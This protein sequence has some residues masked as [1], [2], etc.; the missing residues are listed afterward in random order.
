M[1]DGKRLRLL[2]VGATWPPQ[3][4]L[5]RLMRG[6]ADS[7]VVDVSLAF[8]QKPDQEWFLRSRLRA[9]R[10][11]PWEGPRL[12]RLLRVAWL[13]L[14]AL[15]RSPADFRRYW[16]RSK[17]ENGL[18][19]RL[20]LLNRLLPFAGVSFDVL[21]FPWNSAA[22]DY[23]PLFE[24]GMP[25][26]LSCRGSQI[27]VAPHDP[28]RGIRKGLPGTFAKSA[29]VHC[30]SAAI[31]G[32]AIKFGLD[33]AKSKVIH[34]GI[35]PEFFSPPAARTPSNVLRII[36]VGSLV[37]VKGT[38]YA[39]QALRALLDRGVAAHL[40]L[41]GD[42]PERQRVL[43]T[44]DDL[45]LWDHVELAGRLT[46]VAV[47]DRLREADVFI[48]PSLSEGFCNAAIEA[49]ACGVPVVMSNCGGV[50]EGV[51]DGIEGFIVPTRDPDA[52]A[53]A[54][55]RLARDPALRLQMGLAGRAR[56]L[57]QFALSKHVQAFVRLLEEV[58]DCRVA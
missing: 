32:E 25:V 49:M 46:P 48:L 40:T 11:R 24:N 33:R 2:V 35:D 10:T 19:N 37:W 43:F 13:S 31:E 23:F 58:R 17:A 26:L 18:G 51:T 50:R 16:R 56:V 4:F 53:D 47:R 8:S 12:I 27:N 45:G 55:A 7:G 34:P 57:T 6:L 39:L 1:A 15:V 41:V 54:V 44:I 14:R 38:G 52:M 29:A 21:Y 20:A 9:F 30:V 36:T 5:G 22:I 28:R 42:G 3:T